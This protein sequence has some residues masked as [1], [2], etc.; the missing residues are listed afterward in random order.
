MNI[1]DLVLVC[2]IAV[3]AFVG[4][5]RGLFVSLLSMIRFF[6]GFPLSFA[7]SEKYN[8]VIYDNYVRQVIYNY[9]LDKVN[10]Q[11]NTETYIADLTQKIENLPIFIKDNIDI[12]SLSLVS[13]EKVATYVT[14]TIAHPIAITILKALL[15]IVTLALFYIVTGFIIK[16]IKKIRSKKKN[17]LHK[18]GSFFGLLFGLAKGAGWV[19][20]LCIVANFIV[21]SGFEGALIDT[22]NESKIVEYISSFNLI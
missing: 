11:T 14:D 4:A 20:F 1:I 16:F 2:I 8:Q 17:L 9:I 18:T 21:S 5:K 12:S 10:E 13:N 3:T 7:V 19:L 15:F 6:V 22:I